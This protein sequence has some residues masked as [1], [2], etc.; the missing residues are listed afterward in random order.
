M[1]DPSPPMTEPVAPEG[2]APA[3]SQGPTALLLAALDLRAEGEGC[4][5]A[6]S[7]PGWA[8]RIFGGQF[9]GQSVVAAGRSVTAGMVVH[10]LHATFLRPGDPTQPLRYLVTTLREGRSFATRHVVAR[11]D[12]TDRFVAIV[13]FA[14]PERGLD[15]QPAIDLSAVPPPAGLRRYG[16]WMAETTERP[17]DGYE[18]AERPRPVEVRY[19]DPP[20]NPS[21]EPVTGPQRM[22]LRV[23]GALPDDP[24]L[25]AAALAY[26]SDET[27]IDNV[28]LPHGLR[29]SDPRLQGASLD[30]AMWFCRPAAA[31]RW[32]LFEQTVVSTAAG[33]GLVRGDLYTEAGELVATASQEG[34]MRLTS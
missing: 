31:D 20:P 23:P 3:T 33:R 5:L 10:S 14:R 13:S 19:V 8:A 2:R 25:H 30:H 15:Y 17:E 12:G 18:T 29:W 28:M 24:L 9:L 4:F 34:L 16:E 27:L 11:Q 26:A 6:G 1:T 21:D 7:V 32:L 22:W